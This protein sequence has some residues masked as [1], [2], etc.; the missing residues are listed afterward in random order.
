MRQLAIPDQIWF[1]LIAA[2]A[3]AYNRYGMTLHGT[4]IPNQDGYEL[5]LICVDLWQEVT[6][7]IDYTMIKDVDMLNTFVE[8][9]I[10]PILRT[11]AEKRDKQDKA[12]DIAV[13]G[14]TG[15]DSG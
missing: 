5:R 2:I 7:Q 10:Y 11:L 6:Q 4:I 1:V 3:E 15:I 13:P 12:S 14:A 8:F 9:G